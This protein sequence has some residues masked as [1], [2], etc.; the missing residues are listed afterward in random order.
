MVLEFGLPFD[1]S[2]VDRI[3]GGKL[4]QHHGEPRQLYGILRRLENNYLFLQ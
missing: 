3:M 1:P 4:R 2:I